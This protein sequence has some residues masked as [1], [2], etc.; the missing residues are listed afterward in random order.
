VPIRVWKW[1]EYPRSTEWPG[2]AMGIAYTM[3]D[4][5]DDA[6]RWFDQVTARLRRGWPA[7][8]QID[9]RHWR[10]LTSVVSSQ[11]AIESLAS[12]FD[13]DAT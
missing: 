3:T 9:A 6:K 2:I 13:T 10:L 11:E 5:L 12:Y 1:I 7:Q 4:R 8:E